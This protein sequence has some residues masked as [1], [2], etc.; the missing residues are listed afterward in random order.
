MPVATVVDIDKLPA[1]LTI[2]Q[3]QEITGLSRDLAYRLP[4]MRNFPA[5]RFGRTIRVPRDA[6]VRWLEKQTGLGEGES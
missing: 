2:K 4:H 6:F 1:L 5:V 3:I